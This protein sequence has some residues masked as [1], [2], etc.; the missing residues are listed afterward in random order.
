M[1]RLDRRRPVLHH[2]AQASWRGELDAD[3][4]LPSEE[5]LD[6]NIPIGTQWA[7]YMTR[8]HRGSEVSQ[9]CEPVTILLSSQLA[10]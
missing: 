10:A 2:L 3:R 4:L 6:E 5:I 8:A 1:G 9:G 7:S